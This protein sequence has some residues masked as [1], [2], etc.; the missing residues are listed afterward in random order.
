MRALGEDIGLFAPNGVTLIDGINDFPPQTNNISMGRYPDAALGF[1]Y[2]TNATPGRANIANAGGVNH[3]P[4]VLPIS[5]KYTILGETLSFTVPA[6]DSDVGQTLSYTGSGFPSG[7]T[8]G[9]SSGLFRW[10]PNPSQAPSTTTVNVTATDNGTPPLSNGRSFTIYVTLPP[11]I[12]INRETGGITMAL[13]T[14][15]GR[16]YQVLF[17][18][19]LTDASWS[20]LGGPRTATGS[21]LEIP[22][23]IGSQAQRFYKIQVV[24]Q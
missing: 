8:L 13:P 7:A 14:I 16:Q 4:N 1:Q 24:G 23:V 19:A 6:T 2:M 3:R 21:S 12:T 5:D 22:D 9:L 17:K 18:N 15:A 11:Q 20:P 10:T